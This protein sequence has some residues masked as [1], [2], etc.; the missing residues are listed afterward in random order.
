MNYS[1][2]AVRYS[3]ALF[4]LAEEKGILEEVQKD[5]ALINSVCETE[6]EF[7]RFLDFPVIASTKK[8][9]VLSMIFADKVNK[10]TLE[11][12]K[13]IA[14]NRRESFLPIITR[15]FQNLY[16]TSKGIK[17]VTFTSV[18][19]INDSVRKDIREILRNKYGASIEIVEK[20]N[21]E[22]IGGF[23]LRID[24][25]Q[26]DGSVANQ[27]ENIKRSFKSQK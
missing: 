5:I 26:F 25:D 20:T 1:A 16:K 21:S 19:E 18:S 15:D 22:L 7:K 23:V 8:Y 17:T 3:K 27:L 24:D 11:F 2:I 13:L 10:D 9:E 6:L 4:A 12:L 14:K